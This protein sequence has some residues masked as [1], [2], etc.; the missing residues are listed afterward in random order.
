MADQF[1]KYDIE[2][3][4]RYI[5][6]VDNLRKT[7]PDLTST[8]EVLVDVLKQVRVMQN[9]ELSF[10]YR[11]EAASLLTSSVFL[12]LLRVPL[13]CFISLQTFMQYLVHP[14]TPFQYGNENEPMYEVMHYF[15]ISRP[16]IRSQLSRVLN[17]DIVLE[18]ESAIEPAMINRVIAVSNEPW[19]DDERQ[20]ILDKLNEL[21]NFT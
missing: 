8:Y 3:L 14:M 13:H 12:V 2:K 1:I 18:I 17:M 10:P 15:L 16:Y 6:Q 5:G 7:H 4:E 19:Y 21:R 11:N 9:T 20:E